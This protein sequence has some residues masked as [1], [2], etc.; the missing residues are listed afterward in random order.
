MR[1]SASFLIPLTL[2]AAGLAVRVADPV[3]LQT[4]RGGTFDLYQRL[5]PRSYVPS[6]VRVID[7]DDESLRRI[8]Q[9][10]WPRTVI[11]QWI[12]KLLA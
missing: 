4:L 10:P 2:I 1:V 11:A 8:G 9:W 3:P 12:E 7:I 6:L 5:L